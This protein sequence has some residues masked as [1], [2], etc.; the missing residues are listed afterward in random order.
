MDLLLFCVTEGLSLFD[1]FAFFYFINLFDLVIG[2]HLL[3]RRI[4]G[5]DLRLGPI[6]NYVNFILID[7]LLIVGLGHLRTTGYHLGRL[8]FDN[9]ARGCGLDGLGLFNGRGSRL[10]RG[11]DRTTQQQR[12]HFGRLGPQFLRHAL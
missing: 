12:H 10:G 5:R 3:R 7:Y 11:F 6:I 1:F 2:F 4:A 8:G 9:R